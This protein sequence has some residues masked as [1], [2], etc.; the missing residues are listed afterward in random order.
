MFTLII[1]DMSKLHLYKSIKKVN[2][3]A[4]KILDNLE[5]DID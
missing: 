1:V 3:Q 5:Q 2:T 4:K